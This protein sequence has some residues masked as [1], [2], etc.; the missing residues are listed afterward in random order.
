M[1]VKRCVSNVPQYTF[2]LLSWGQLNKFFSVKLQLYTIIFMLYY[3]KHFN[4]VIVSFI[5]TALDLEDMAYIT[6]HTECH[7]KH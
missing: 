3:I 2:I 1:D 4:S 6:L 5:L 7:Y